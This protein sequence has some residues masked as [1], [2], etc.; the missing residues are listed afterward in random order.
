MHETSHSISSPVQSRTSLAP[1]KFC[2]REIFGG[3]KKDF[4]KFSAL[5]S[6]LEYESKII[7][8]SEKY[9]VY[10]MGVKGFRSKMQGREKKNH[11]SKN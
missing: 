10:N 8:E 4:G 6:S 9:S 2:R 7:Q 5:K 11:A 3:L 1:R